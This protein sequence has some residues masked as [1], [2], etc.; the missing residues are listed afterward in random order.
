[1]SPSDPALL[2]PLLN[3]QR[4]V[5]LLAFLLYG[6]G[7]A[8]TTMTGLTTAGVAEAGPVAIRLLAAFGPLGFLLQ[9]MLLFAGALAIWSLVRTPGRV[10]V[11]LA[12]AVA[13]ALVTGWN[14]F[15]LFW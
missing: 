14:L 10:A 8:A 4:D 3:R 13:G 12:L 5:W 9:K 1:M 11:P 6:V 15:V 2:S 7:D